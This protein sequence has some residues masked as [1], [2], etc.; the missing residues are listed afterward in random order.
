M[1]ADEATPAQ[2]SYLQTLPELPKN[3]PKDLTAIRLAKR[4]LARGFTS[5]GSKLYHLIKILFH[6]HF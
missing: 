5:S 2:L 6:V 1:L 4:D 3:I